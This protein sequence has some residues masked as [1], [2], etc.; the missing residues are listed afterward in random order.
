M[1]RKLFART[2]GN[3]RKLNPNTFTGLQVSPDL[4]TDS[5]GYTLLPEASAQSPVNDGVVGRYGMM[6]PSGIIRPT[7]PSTNQKDSLTG[8]AGSFYTVTAY[9]AKG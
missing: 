3:L 7:N 8:S 9:H 1:R 6:P 2:I 4:L 5:N